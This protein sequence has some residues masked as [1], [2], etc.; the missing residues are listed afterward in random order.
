MLRKAAGQA[1]SLLVVRDA[2]GA[3]FGAYA[4]E[5]WHMAPRF[6]GTGETFV[7]SVRRRGLPRGGSGPSRGRAQ[8]LGGLG[9]PHVR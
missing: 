3:V 9:A 1:P 7:F 2:A 5:A 8:G 4:A 6:Y